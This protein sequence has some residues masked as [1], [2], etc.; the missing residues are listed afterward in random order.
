MEGIVAAF[1]PGYVLYFLC[2]FGAYAKA[3]QVSGSLK[4]C[5]GPN[6]PF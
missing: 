6:Q 1:Y 5:E 4:T 2:N 3:M